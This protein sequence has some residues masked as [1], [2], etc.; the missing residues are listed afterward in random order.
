M[1]FYCTGEACAVEWHSILLPQSR[2][3]L[4]LTSV[5]DRNRQCHTRR[6]TRS[7][8]PPRWHPFSVYSTSVSSVTYTLEVYNDA[9]SHT[10]VCKVYICHHDDRR[11]FLKQESNDGALQFVRRYHNILSGAG[12]AVRAETEIPEAVNRKY[13][14]LKPAITTGAVF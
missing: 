6:A 9:S 5:S 11:R 3:H 10:L 1:P 7:L 14:C 8:Y 13:R 4:V 12:C 2:Y